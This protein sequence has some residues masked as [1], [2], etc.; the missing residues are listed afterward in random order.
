MGRGELKRI[1]TYLDNTTYNEINIGH[2]HIQKHISYKN[3]IKIQTCVQAHT[4]VFP[5]YFIL[6]EKIFEEYFNV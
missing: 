2:Y 1:L 3:D 6:R 4:K 5:I